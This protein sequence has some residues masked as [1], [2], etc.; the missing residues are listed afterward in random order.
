MLSNAC[1]HWIPMHD[2]LFDHLLPQLAAGGVLAFQVPNNF[3]EPSHTVVAETIGRPP[4]DK[5][6]SGVRQASVQDPGWYVEELSNR[7][8]T[9]NAWEITYH[10]VL[11]GEDAVLGWLAGTTLRPILSVLDQDDRERF[12]DDCANPLA[13]AYPRR[14]IGTIFPFRRIFVV[15]KAPV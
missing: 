8:L 12:L 6:L 14:A 10:H 11:E 7:G 3:A 4:W 1:F 13:E 5:K 9:V 15:A 2:Q